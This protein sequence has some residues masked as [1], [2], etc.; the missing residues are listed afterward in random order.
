MKTITNMRQSFANASQE[1]RNALVVQFD[2][3]I[4]KITAQEYH[5]V[6]Y[7]WDEIYSMAL[8]GFVNAMN[9]YDPERSTMTFAQYA[10]FAMLNSLSLC[11]S[12]KF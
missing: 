11:L 2:K 10:G 1:T 4:N 6:D 3:L 8:E 12:L 9:E 5:K 7:P